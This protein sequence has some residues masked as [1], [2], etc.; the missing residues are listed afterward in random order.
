MGVKNNEC[1]IATTWS[2]NDMQKVKDWVDELSRD[3][4]SLFCFIPSLVNNKITL[5]LAPDGSK[6]GWDTAEHG[7]AL[8]NLLIEL[9]KTFD[10]D[11]GSNPF[12]WVEVGY[13]EFGQEVLR[14]NCDN[15]YS[16]KPYAK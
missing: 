16:N 4:Q 2:K 12:E 9:L 10:D 6:K 11:D 15:M 8:R 3:D 7:E 14:G 1:V 5:F 13:G